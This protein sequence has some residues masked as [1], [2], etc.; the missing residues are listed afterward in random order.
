MVQQELHQRLPVR[1]VAHADAF[2]ECARTRLQLS[3]VHEGEGEQMLGFFFGTFVAKGGR[4]AFN[5][6]VEVLGFV[7]ATGSV[8]PSHSLYI[9]Q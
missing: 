5:D 2:V 8:Q 4:D 3:G 9:Q 7:E 6:G 1:L